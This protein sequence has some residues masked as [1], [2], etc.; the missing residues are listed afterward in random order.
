M[1]NNIASRQ[2]TPTPSIRFYR[3]GQLPMA[4]TFP[5]RLFGLTIG[6]EA[7]LE[8]D[9]FLCKIQDIPRWRLLVPTVYQC[10]AALRSK[11]QLD[12]PR[13]RHSAQNC[14]AHAFAKTI[15]DVGLTRWT[16]YRRVAFDCMELLK[17]R[18][19]AA[20]R[21]LCKTSTPPANLP[22][23]LQTNLPPPLLDLPRNLDNPPPS[24]VTTVAINQPST[25]A[26]HQ[27]SHAQLRHDR[28]DSNSISVSSHQEPPAHPPPSNP[29]KA[30]PIGRPTST[31]DTSEST[32]GLASLHFCPVKLEVQAGRGS[33]FAEGT[34]EDPLEVS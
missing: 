8:A 26:I 22:P 15:Y 14:L 31:E 3:Q 34:K 1:E 20:I 4:D 9:Y 24:A 23:P 5:M 21:F 28:K 7:T 11:A 32:I 16:S 17:L 33:Y 13:Q 30:E 2:G 18:A 29:A 19:S 6:L 25:S 12:T 10:R 27:A